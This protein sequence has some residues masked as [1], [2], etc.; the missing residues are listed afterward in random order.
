MI[1]QE[2]CFLHFLIHSFKSCR[3]LSRGLAG[4]IGHT[5]VTAAH[6]GHIL[7]GYR[8]AGLI[9]GQTNGIQHKLLLQSTGQKLPASLLSALRS[10]LFFLPALVLLNHFR[11]LAGI[12]EAQPLTFVL[13]SFTAVF[14]ALDFFRRLPKEDRIQ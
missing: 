7:G 8:E 1:L 3:S 4:Q 14:F 2:I 10:G 9:H 6:V 5:D 11:G 13:S 12:Q